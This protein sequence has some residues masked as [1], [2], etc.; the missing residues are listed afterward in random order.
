M[1]VFVRII[2]VGLIVSSW[3]LASM[4]DPLAFRTVALGMGLF[5]AGV[6][7]PV[8]ERTYEVVDRQAT[9]LFHKAGQKFSE[10]RQHRMLAA[11]TVR[12]VRVRADEQP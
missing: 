12:V 2:S 4:K 11:A 1:G 3:L 10:Y 5:A 9:K 8:V 7:W 6:I